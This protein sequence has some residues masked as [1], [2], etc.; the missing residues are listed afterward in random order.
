M[1]C[2]CGGEC[3]SGDWA[4]L[5]HWLFKVY[6]N[7]NIQ[8][9]VAVKTFWSDGMVPQLIGSPGDPEFNKRVRLVFRDR[10]E[11]LL[12]LADADAMKSEVN[13]LLRDRKLDINAAAVEFLP[14]T[15]EWIF[16][17][18]TFISYDRNDETPFEESR[19]TIAHHKPIAFGT[20]R[21]TSGEIP[22][23]KVTCCVIPFR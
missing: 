15:G 13:K 2:Q 6:V 4:K 22:D 21:F 23:S 14:K 16:R 9:N 1:E 11:K 8:R 17:N 18:G 12:Q 5:C 10:A 20:L 19:G 3:F 7:G